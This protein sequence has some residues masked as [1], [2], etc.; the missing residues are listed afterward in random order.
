MR[1][2]VR[3]QLLWLALSML[4]GCAGLRGGGVLEGAY[5]ER[6]WRWIANADGRALL[7]HQRLDKCFI[8]PRPD[9]DF[10]SQGFVVK[11]EQRA[12]GGTPYEVI[13]LFENGEFWESL[14]LRSGSKVPLMGVY[15]AGECQKAA[16]GILE[17]YERTKAR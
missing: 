6:E 1:Y 5:D 14:Y 4:A 16:E 9:E 13:S 15:T 8:D 10:E 3:A 2:N 12:I 11:R 7:Q 17:Q